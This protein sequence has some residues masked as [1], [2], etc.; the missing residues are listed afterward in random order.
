MEKKK[1]CP[2]CGE[3][4]LEVAKKCKYCGEWLN[5]SYQE[6]KQFSCP[7]C[8]EL[9]DEGTAVCPY[10]KGD[11]IKQEQCIVDNPIEKEILQSKEENSH[12][13]FISEIIQDTQ[14]VQ[15]EGLIG[16]EI[17]SQ[18]TSKHLIVGSLII[19][20]II[21]ILRVLATICFSSWI[22]ED[23][24]ILDNIYSEF[25][26]DFALVGLCVILIGI[27]MLIVYKVFKKPIF[28]SNKKILNPVIVVLV[29]VSFAEI[30]YFGNRTYWKASIFNDAV[31]Q[32]NMG[33]KEMEVG[34]KEK[35]I[36]WYQKAFENGHGF[37]AYK[38]ARC[39][40][41]GNGVK[42]NKLK[43]IEYYLK[44][45]DRSIQ[46]SNEIYIDAMYLYKIY[47]TKLDYKNAKRC[48]DIAFSATNIQLVP[49]EDSIARHKL[50]VRYDNLEHLQNKLNVKLGE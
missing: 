13:K 15:D 1:K 40:D 23:Y 3:E 37:A 7:I 38:I 34:D 28:R 32:Y 45:L 50:S 35:A 30:T 44:A 18:K 16:S 29:L 6:K 46:C 11:I 2:Y 42:Q 24:R 43:A 41:E 9:I 31:S 47:Y 8:G 22:Y 49:V 14:T 36:D 21:T 26:I 17:S 20:L 5:G 4:I 39:Y 33:Q 25:D 10:C 19:M 12:H 48:I 27:L